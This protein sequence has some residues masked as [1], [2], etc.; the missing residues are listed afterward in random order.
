MFFKNTLIFPIGKVY[1][2]WRGVI[3]P[4]PVK[5]DRQARQKPMKGKE[6]CK[7]G[8][9]RSGRISSVSIRNS[10]IVVMNVAFYIS[11]L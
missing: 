6:V 8:E 1:R 10:C 2:D 5:E 4:V 7:M 3:A 11:D 9:Y